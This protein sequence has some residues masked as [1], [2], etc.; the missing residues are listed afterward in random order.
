MSFIAEIF[1]FLYV[2]MDSE[3][4]DL[5]D[6]LIIMLQ[7]A[8]VVCFVLLIFCCDTICSYFCFMDIDFNLGC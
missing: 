7:S 4:I 5:V 2:G 1:I 8:Q 6:E 3:V